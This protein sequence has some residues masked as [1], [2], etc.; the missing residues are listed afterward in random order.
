M[1]KGIA[2][3]HGEDVTLKK[4][5]WVISPFFT[6]SL[7]SRSFRGILIYTRAF[8][9]AKKDELQ[10]KRPWNGGQRSGFKIPPVSTVSLP[11][12]LEFGLTMVQNLSEP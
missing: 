4:V 12:A 2:T 6:V 9:S 7:L 10:K 3:R 11:E 1:S 8:G 5:K